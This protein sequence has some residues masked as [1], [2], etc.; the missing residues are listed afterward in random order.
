MKRSPTYEEFKNQI[1]KA[2]EKLQHSKPQEA[3]YVMNY[4]DLKY[5]YDLMKREDH[6]RRLSNLIAITS[7]IE[8][9][10]TLKLPNGRM[11]EISYDELLPLNKDVES[12]VE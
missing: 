11:I 3:Q 2:K 7:D 5:I 9:I 4:N 12:V 1:Y 6:I 8:R 10:Y